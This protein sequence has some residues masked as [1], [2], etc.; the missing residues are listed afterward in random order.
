MNWLRRLFLGEQATPRHVAELE[1]PGELVELRGIVET[2]GVILNPLNGSESVMLH[3]SARISAR[4]D[5]QLGLLDQAAL[6]EFRQGTNFLLRDASGVAMIEVETGDN[7]VEEH[8]RLLT[9]YGPGIEV[10]V[11]A[12][13]PGDRIVVRGRVRERVATTSP[14]R[15]ATWSAVVTKPTIERQ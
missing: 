8:G 2:L 10:D 9:Q 13:S 6:V 12:I 11:N 7:I 5:P 3:F 1:T 15:S 14:H 4:A